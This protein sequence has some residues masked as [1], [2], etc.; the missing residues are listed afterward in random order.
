MRLR[1]FCSKSALM[2]VL[3]VPCAILAT[4]SARAQTFTVLHSFGGGVSG[5]YPYGGLLRDSA[6]NLYGTTYQGGDVSSGN[7]GYGMAFELAA[8]AGK[9]T[10]L[11]NFTGGADGSDPMGNLIVDGAGNFYG[12]TSGNGAPYFGTIF[13]LTHSGD[14]W[15][16]TVL[17]SFTGGTDGS[18]P[19]GGL[20]IDAAGNLYGTTAGGGAGGFGTVFKLDTSG[21]ETVLH[22]FAGGPDDGS[23]PAG[24]L[25]M[26]GAGNLYGTMRAGA[27]QG[28]GGV[29]EVDKADTET[30]LFAFHWFVLGVAPRASLVM[31]AAGNIYGTT[32]NGGSVE[33]PFCG[34]V[35]KLTLSGG[36]WIE[37]SLHSFQG[38]TDGCNPWAGLVIDPAG[39]LYG[40]TSQGGGT[41]NNGYGYGTVFK[42]DA[43]GKETILYSFTGGT[44]GRFPGYGSLVRAA[45]NLYGTTIYGGNLSCNPPKGCGV[46]F[47]LNP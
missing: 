41:G 20:V 45:G 19:N 14:V 15:T 1:Q 6:G 36:V 21:T 5:K 31:D 27:G 47:K 34:T 7:A 11:H 24:G 28:F 10:S 8:P 33:P 13:K 32:Y 4:Q 2:A 35:F 9:E 43:T 37:S 30:V 17:Y 46:V 38:G 40:T 18:N 16:E 3:L 44:D 25:L 23:D 29:F 12:T 39:N 26:D 22:S 42:L